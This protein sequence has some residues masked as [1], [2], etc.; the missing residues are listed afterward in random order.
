MFGARLLCVGLLVFSFSAELRAEEEVPLPTA[1]AVLGDSISEAIFAEYGIEQGIPYLELVRILGIAA[2]SDHRR[3]INAYR[4]NYAAYQYSWASGDDPMSFVY[5]H[6]ERLQRYVPEL[7]AWN[8]AVAAARAEELEEQLDRLFEIQSEEGVIFDYITLLIGG[9]DLRQ[10]QVSEMTPPMEFIGN[11]EVNL[12]RLLD[13]E[14]DRRVLLVGLPPMHEVF[15]RTKHIESV[16]FFGRAQTC[17]QVRKR[18][19]GNLPQFDSEHEDYQASLKIVELYERGLQSLVDRLQLDYP[20]A[21]LKLVQ[22]Y[23]TTQ[24]PKKALSVDC[25]HPSEWGQAELAETT[26]FKGFWPHL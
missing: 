24:L 21:D 3:K 20:K 26:W 12:R 1:M 25:F 6:F 10:E 22:N 15:E 2:I 19:Y 14:P 17:A 4:R 5:S 13:Q 16:R 11:L 18:V 23:Q 9:N 8:L 7:E